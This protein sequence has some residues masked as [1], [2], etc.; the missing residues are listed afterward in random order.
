MG[1]ESYTPPPGYS[2]ILP[3]ILFCPVNHVAMTRDRVVIQETL[4]PTFKGELPRSVYFP[5]EPSTIDRDISQHIDGISTTFRSHHTNYYH[6]LVDNL[7][8]IF[9]L[10][11]EPWVNLP[12]IKILVGGP[13]NHVESTFL[14]Q[15]LPD[16]ATI[17]NLHQEGLAAVDNFVFLSFLSERN[18]G[19]LPKSYVS[20]LR[21]LFAP[22]RESRKSHRIYISREKADT[23]RV[24][25]RKEIIHKHNLDLYCLEDLPIQDQIELFYDSELIVSPHGAGLS[26]LLFSPSQT[27]VIELFPSIPYPYYYYLSHYLDHNYRYLA[28]RRKHGNDDF[29]IQTD[30]ISTALD[31]LE[32]L[33]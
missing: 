33:R 21:S 19:I 24:L 8:R 31:S 12:E 25:N 1:G 20:T 32:A 7:P 28:D 10:H 18:N 6:T 5:F 9:L 2:T 14:E 29:R 15:L 26:N 4:K 17:V 23:R 3:D 22:R 27:N 13:L 16:N 11:H 30:L